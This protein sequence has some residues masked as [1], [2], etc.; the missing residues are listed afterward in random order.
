MFDYVGL[1]SG[2]ASRN[3]KSTCPVYTDFEDKLKIQ[4]AKTPALYF[5]ACGNRDFVF[6]GVTDF[7]K[8]LDDN[9]CK[10][11]Y[12]ET[13]EGHIWRNWRIYL[14]EFVPKLFK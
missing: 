1:F 10:Y 8:L 4:F 3:D 14:T 7:R 13:G 6:K 9:G 12:L 5:I 11:E 2:T